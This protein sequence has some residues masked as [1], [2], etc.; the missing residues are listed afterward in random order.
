MLVNF[1][2]WGFLIQILAFWSAVDYN[3]IHL[4]LIS[5]IVLPGSYLQ[6]LSSWSYVMIILI[7]YLCSLKNSWCV[8]FNSKSE[9]LSAAQGIPH[10]YG[11]LRFIPLALY[12]NKP[13]ESNICYTL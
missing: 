3:K 2:W 11:T 6:L 1:A 5:L 12:R 10:V 13:V 8:L 9:N 7:S 4:L